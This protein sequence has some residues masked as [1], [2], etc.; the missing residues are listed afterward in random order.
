M[1]LAGTGTPAIRPT[2]R[3][4]L[5]TAL[6]LIRRHHLNPHDKGEPQ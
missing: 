6:E 5:S 2:F 1:P 3:P 4:T